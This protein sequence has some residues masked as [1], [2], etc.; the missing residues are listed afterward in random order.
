[1]LDVELE[2]VL[3]I[4]TR[5]PTTSIISK[6][7]TFIHIIFVDLTISYSEMVQQD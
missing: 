1:M 7:R 4:I 2:E 5:D 3:D 6:K